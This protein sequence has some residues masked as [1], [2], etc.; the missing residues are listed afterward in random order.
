MRIF[1][2]ICFYSTTVVLVGILFA[3]GHFVIGIMV[4]AI[5]SAISTTLDSNQLLHRIR[6][7]ENE[8]EA[9][10]LEIKK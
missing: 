9:L 5:I 10:K 2:H 6:F 8:V 3:Y 1:F 4:Y 7:L